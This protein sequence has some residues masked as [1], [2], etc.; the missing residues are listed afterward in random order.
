[1]LI[2]NIKIVYRPVMIVCVCRGVS[3]RDVVE[4]VRGGA[5]TV[6]D[7]GRRCG[8]AGTDCGSCVRH[9]AGH[10]PCDDARQSA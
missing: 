9:I 8:G 5:R 10:L 1:M 2:T 7:V 6:E 3:D 4:A